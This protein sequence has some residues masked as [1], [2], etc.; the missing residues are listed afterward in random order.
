MRRSA[1]PK[2]VLVA[3]KVD[4]ETAAFLDALP[5]KSEFVRGALRARLEETCPLCQ[6]T[7]LRPPAHVE[8]PGGRHLHALPRARCRDCGRETPVVADV[9]ASQADRA[10]LLREANRLRTFLAYGDYF[11]VACYAR[12]TSCDRCGHRIAGG[13]PARDAHACGA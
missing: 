13:G 6:G 2:S 1:A 12:S 4:A 5:N 8:R 3:V 7:G 10:G 9:D 11:C